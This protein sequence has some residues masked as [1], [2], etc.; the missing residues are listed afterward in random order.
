VA[1]Y[2]GYQAVFFKRDCKN[3][4]DAFSSHNS[5]HNELGDI[6]TQC[7]SLLSTNNNY[8]VTMS[9]GKQTKFAHCVARAS[10]SHTSPYIYH[11]IPVSII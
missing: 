1:N 10:L 4:V 9:S 3:I 11:D 5:P 8:V 6:I 7:T 2:H